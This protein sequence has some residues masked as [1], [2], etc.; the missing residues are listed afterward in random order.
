MDGINI[1]KPHGNTGSAGTSNVTMD[2]SIMTVEAAQRYLDDEAY[3]N[4]V[5]AHVKANT[6]ANVHFVF[7]RRHRA[8]STAENLTILAGPRWAA[9]GQH[10]DDLPCIIPHDASW[11]DP[12]L[13]YPK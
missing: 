13:T 7:I 3:R 12:K 2:V 8:P 4:E 6:P 5:I 10:E 11:R 1:K 9:I